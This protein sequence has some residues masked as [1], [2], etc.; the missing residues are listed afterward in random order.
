M[1]CLAR[2]RPDLAIDLA[3]IVGDDEDEAYPTRAAGL[4][5]S[6]WLEG[7]RMGIAE[8]SGTL[9]DIGHSDSLAHL[10]SAL[11]P[12]LLHYGL[13]DLDGGDIRKRAPRRFTQE[14]SRYVYE[15]ATAVGEPS[16]NGIRYGSRLGDELTNWALFEPGEPIVLVAGEPVS[17]DD[18]DLLAVLERFDL[19]LE[20]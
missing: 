5:P 13:D 15:Q 18:P 20:D 4:V 9:C 6:G 14:I 16:F 2:F 3:A 17:A 12:Q 19:T 10:R 1:E 7:R 8:L 11:A